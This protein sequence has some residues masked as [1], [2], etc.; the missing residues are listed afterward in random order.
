MNLRSAILV[1]ALLLSLALLLI[2]E[3]SPKAPAAREHATGQKEEP[4][5]TIMGASV[6][7]FGEDGALNWS[8]QSPSIA[9]HLDGDL[10]FAAPNMLLQGASNANLRASAGLGT[11]QEAGGEE[12]IVL[13]SR[14][15]AALQRGERVKDEVKFDTERLIISAQGRQILAPESVRIS[16]HSIETRAAELDLDLQKQLLLLASNSDEKVTTRIAPMSLFE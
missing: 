2:Q 9:Y 6:R 13:Y 4:D 14:V 12:T 7:S 11:L 5:L 8:M 1:G 10:A 3:P 15:S 16:A